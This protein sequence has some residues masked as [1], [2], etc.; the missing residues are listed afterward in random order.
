MTVRDNG[1]GASASQLG[2]SPG[3]GLARLRE[4]LLVLYAGGAR[5]DITTG[6]S[7]GFTATL[8]IPQSSE[9]E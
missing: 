2:A 9:A 5:L 8:V 7:R 6:A 4:R 1:A 3:T